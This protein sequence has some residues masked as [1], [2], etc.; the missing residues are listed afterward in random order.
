V[1][2]I[3]LRQK[4]ANEKL[5]IV[6]DGTQ[7]R[8]FTHVSDVVQI[9]MLAADTN[10]ENCFGETFNVGTGTNQSILEVAKMIEHEYTMIEPRLGEAETTL[11]DIS[12]AKSFL[13]Y[14]PSV[15]LEDWIKNNK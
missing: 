4:A 6:G 5:T 12:K 3:F 1:I 11:A 8:D 7:R 10:N 9:N 2:G 13:N 14:E 15:K